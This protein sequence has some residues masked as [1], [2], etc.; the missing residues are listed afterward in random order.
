[1]R[2][3]VACG[4]LLACLLA[5]QPARAVEPWRVLI[6][7]DGHV[8]SRQPAQRAWS[9]VWRSR[10]LS[11]GDRAR[12]L[13]ASRAR[14]RLAD[15]SGFTVGAD[16]EVEMTRFRLTPEGRAVVFDLYVG[17]VRARV[18]RVLGRQNGF[19]VRTPNGVLAARGTEF[20]VEQ[21]PGFLGRLDG[22][23][24]S[25]AE[26][27]PPHPGP[28]W[29]MVFSGRVDA[30]AGGAHQ[31]FF[32]GD[33]GLID[34]DGVIHLNP[35]SVLPGGDRGPL[36]RSGMDADLRLPGLGE[37]APARVT[38][39]PS[40]TEGAPPPIYAPGGVPIQPAPRPPSSPTVPPSTS[41]T[42]PGI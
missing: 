18:A 24:A 7:I 34:A 28:T 12:T 5:G 40:A 30:A 2:G 20:Y 26:V 27:Q 14:V 42:G 1:M 8:E 6:R 41:P 39:P 13:V 29:F 21:G 4:M 33:W 37:A 10:I 16:S 38:R 35:P 25:L 36:G 3:Y 9:P 11:D 32:G 15:G 17:R 19:E 22:R 31:S 23:T